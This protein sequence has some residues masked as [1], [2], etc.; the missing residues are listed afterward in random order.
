MI[1]FKNNVGVFDNCP[2]VE[3]ISAYTYRELLQ[4]YHNK[5]KETI[6]NFNKVEEEFKNLDDYCK[7]N[8]EYLLNNGMYEELKKYM[9]QLYD[10]GLLSSIV[11]ENLLIDL[12]K[13]FESII[14]LN[15]LDYGGVNDGKTDNRVALQNLI[16]QLKNRG[17]GK[18]FFPKGS[19]YFSRKEN[20]I[21]SINVESNISFIGSG[22]GTT[23]FLI[24]D[25][26]KENDE[27][28]YSLF[29]HN[30]NTSVQNATY[31]NFT[32]D[33]YKMTINEELNGYT[34]KG[35]ALFFEGANNC[36]FRDLELKGTPSTAFGVDF[37]NNCIIDNVNCYECGR[38]W[39][40]NFGDGKG[41]IIEAPG[42]AGI[43]IGT[44]LYEVENVKIV[45]CTCV[46]C[47]HYG[48]FLEHQNMFNSYANKVSKGN[49]IVNNIVHH[50][51]HGGIGVRGGS[52]VIV[53]NNNV[54]ENKF[55]VV[56]DSGETSIKELLTIKDLII[57][58]NVIKG[59]TE[60]AI[61][62]GNNI[63]FDN[64]LISNNIIRYNSTGIQFINNN[65]SVICHNLKLIGNIY[66][67]NSF[68]DLNFIN[69]N[70]KGFENNDK[71]SI[72][73]G[74]GYFNPKSY[75]ISN[76]NIFNNFQS[77][78]F[79]FSFSNI[80]NQALFSTKQEE[81]TST[82]EVMGMTLLLNDENKLVLRYNLETGGTRKTITFNKVFEKDADITIKIYR[83]SK[84]CVIKYKIND[85]NFLE[86][87][88]DSNN[89]LNDI[90]KAFSINKDK[91][92]YF[93]KEY[94]GNVFKNYCGGLT[95]YYLSI[96]DKYNNSKE[97]GFNNVGIDKII[98]DENESGYNIIPHDNFIQKLN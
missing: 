14:G 30:R 1:E 52:N 91:T 21:Y 31:T 51:K 15:F 94:D 7:S 79:K 53:S 6:E 63:N 3:N 89:L 24:G 78:E 84:Q 85:E 27:E 37:M 26:T 95:I 57:N 55:G 17:G 5:I 40:E 96:T 64:V 58:S 82:N 86:L 4:Y 44:G 76:T 41:H 98:K 28:G 12:D 33:A 60:S 29:Y 81:N 13:R 47:G 36:V 66:N 74:K 77:L 25:G 73:C 65:P 43:G 90:E 20:T 10:E 2:T 32:V 48:I 19:Y 67:N 54:Y 42:G 11:N 61:K 70:I 87:E 62:L 16:N 23:I 49:I 18:I 80:G 46:K 34:H 68:K 45:N 72:V 22:M 71:F 9:K 59:N 92:L 39:L 88:N 38:L 8:I 35:K 75:L 56:I 50:C 83:D 69:V 97:Y 93:G